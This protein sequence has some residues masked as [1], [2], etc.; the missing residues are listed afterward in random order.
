MAKKQKVRRSKQFSIP[1][2]I[3]S[4]FA[5]LVYTT[6]KHTQWNGFGGEEGGMDVFV[7]SLTGFSPNTAYGKVWEFK[8]MLWGAIPILG[9]FMVHKIAGRIG[10]NRAIAS[11]GIPFI[12]I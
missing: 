5:P 9:G 2:A 11:A 8:R 1:L 4:G 10:I 6:Y 3:V 7:R 12:R